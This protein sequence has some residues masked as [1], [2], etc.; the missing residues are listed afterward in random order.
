MVE[1]GNTVRVT[2]EWVLQ[3]GGQDWKLEYHFKDHC[4][5]SWQMVVRNGNPGQWK[6]GWL[7]S[8]I[9]KKYIGAQIGRM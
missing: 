4:A 5:N 9:F 2:E 8:D 3:N 7:R 1:A 6:L